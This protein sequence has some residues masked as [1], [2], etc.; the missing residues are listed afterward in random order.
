MAVDTERVIGRVVI[1]VLAAMSLA[2][3]ALGVIYVAV[4]CQSLPSFLGA[5]PGETH[6]RTRLGAALLILAVVFAAAAYA[7]RRRSTAT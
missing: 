3:T 2:A 7:S 4:A 6:P 5:V 1:P